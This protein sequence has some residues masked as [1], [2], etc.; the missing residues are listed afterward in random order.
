MTF[1][2]FVRLSGMSVCLIGLVVAGAAQAR[3]VSH[4]QEATS[5]STATV[6]AK[7]GVE[8]SSKQS[9]TDARLDIKDSRTSTGLSAH[10]LHC[11]FFPVI[12]RWIC[13]PMN[14]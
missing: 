1:K 14:Y 7:V 5:R 10:G 6:V 3:A 13:E 12:N 4:A 9:Q 8:T 11:A 2:K